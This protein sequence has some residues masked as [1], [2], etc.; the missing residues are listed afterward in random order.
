MM[1]ILEPLNARDSVLLSV[2]LMFFPRGKR[3]KQSDHMKTND[4]LVELFEVNA[5]D[6]IARPVNVS[7]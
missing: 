1:G 7:R 4:K 2:S 3:R 6:Y 5:R